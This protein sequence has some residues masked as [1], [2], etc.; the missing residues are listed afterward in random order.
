MIIEIKGRPLPNGGYVTTYDDI[1][2]FIIA[3]RQLE[4]ANVN[5]EKR[6]Q[7]RTEK[8]EEINYDLV[9]EIERRGEV[10]S[11]LRAAKRIADDANASKTKFLAL[12]SHD[13]MQPLNA[14]NLY[15]SAL[16]PPHTRGPEET[17]IAW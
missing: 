6:V 17:K 5:L 8:I 14:A 11:E 16:H 2:E 1:T 3:Q 13:I 15:V 9:K 12:A 10:E 4:D 7:E